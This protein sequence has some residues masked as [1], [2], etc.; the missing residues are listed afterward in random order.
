MCRAGF[1]V[2]TAFEHVTVRETRACAGTRSA[3]PLSFSRQAE[4]GCS[5]MPIQLLHK[6]AGPGHLGPGHAIHRKIITDRGAVT[7]ARH[8]R[9]HNCRPLRLCNLIL[10]QV[11]VLGERYLVQRFII[12]NIIPSLVFR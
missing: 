10:A 1:T 3:F 6:A 5:Q 8:G 12:K 11:I 7:I 4:G 9:S 2:V